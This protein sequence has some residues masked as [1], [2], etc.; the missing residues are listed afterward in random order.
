MP[1]RTVRAV[2]A[3]LSTIAPI[4]RGQQAHPLQIR[5]LLNL[6]SLP[7]SDGF[8]SITPD[9]RWVAYAV[10]DA[11]DWPATDTT[12]A[13][14]VT[15]VVPM[16]GR[17][18]QVWV[19]DT[20]SGAS[21]CITN[22]EGTNWGPAWSPDGTQL[23]FYSDR[24]GLARLWLWNRETG[25]LRRASDVVVRP[26]YDMPVWSPDGRW[27][28]V[29]L[30]REGQTVLRA[31][32]LGKRGGG[33]SVADSTVAAGAT[34]AVFRAR[35]KPADL[36]PAARSNIGAVIDTTQMDGPAIVATAADL[37][38]VNAADGSVR[39]LAQSEELVEWYAF[40]PDGASVAFTRDAGRLH[41]TQ[42]R[43]ADLYVVPAAGGAAHLVASRIRATSPFVA[44]SPDGRRLAY[45][46]E[47]PLTDGEVYVV[48]VA[49]ATPRRVTPNGHPR[50]EEQYGGYPAWLH[51]SARGD[52]L[53]FPGAGRLWMA[54]PDGGPLTPLT[55]DD[56]DHEVVSVIANASRSVAFSPNGGATVT[57][58]TRDR[59][60]KQSG[61]Y[62]VNVRTRQVIR[63]R[64]EA[65]FYGILF[66]A[67]IV[68][69]DG[70][71]VLYTSQDAQRP[72][73]LWVAN[74][75]LATPRQ[76]THLNPTIQPDNLGQVRVI[77][78]RG[79]DGE[80]LQG[81]LLLPA[82][83]QPGRR[84]PL[85]VRVYPENTS[86]NS[87]AAF[88]FGLDGSDCFANMQLLASRGYAVLQPDIPQRVG[89]P[90]KDLVEG[91]DLA[92]NKV[93]E[94]GIADSHRLGVFGQSYGGYA[95]IAIITQTSRFRA[96][97]MSAGSADLLGPWV[98]GMQ[99]NG[100]SSEGWAETG[101][102]L[103]GGTPWQYRDRYIENSPIFY[104]DQV[105]TPLLIIHGDADRPESAD[106]V[107]VGLRWLGKE[108]EYRRY[109]GVGHVVSGP[110][111]LTDYWNALFRWFDTYLGARE[112]RLP[113]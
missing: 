54:H 72:Q 50:F 8:A 85:L 90:M 74:P 27:I 35:A 89:T 84:Y 97:V 83:Y 1:P 31:N 34:V 41:G 57:I 71:T 51:W 96:A 44:W 22:D 20:R 64:E 111:N 110:E 70:S 81:A 53:F 76:L 25:A 91:V 32:R 43:L 109:A 95:T 26:F 78:Y 56:W 17:A 102:G 49:T 108:V 86:V 63:L 42:Q 5:D 33:P 6:K 12:M 46:T 75:D 37:G 28:A 80:V 67:P 48:D 14:S 62:R 24:D 93:I 82:Q 30:L 65:R 112:Q 13:F 106:Q 11:R 47:G 21:R 87:D 15:G 4:L 103:M 58:T 107:F 61:F 113:D 10:R 101:Q 36:S 55:P 60:S 79:I 7:H 77:A 88:R 40:A 100:A 73:D 68:S 104:L 69:A 94:L 18:T 105:T 45:L 9:G 66:G 92:V 52:A 23:A 29:K 98:L 19:A 99:S 3:L 16:A 2:V 38:L 39:R 59:T